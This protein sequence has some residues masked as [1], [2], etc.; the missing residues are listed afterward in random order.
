MQAHLTDTL[1]PHTPRQRISW[2]AKWIVVIACVIWFTRFAYLRI[3]LRPT[4][5]PEYWEGQIAALDPPGPNA[6][7][8][9][10][11]RRVFSNSGWQPISM[12]HQAWEPSDLLRGKWDSARPDVQLFEAAFRSAA[13]EAARAEVLR[14]VRVGWPLDFMPVPNAIHVT[15]FGAANWGRTLVAH[16]R[17]LRETSG[18]TETAFED[19]RTALQLGR[20]LCRA[21]LVEVLYG[22]SMEALVAREMMIAAREPHAQIEVR[23]LADFAA[24]LQ[25]LPFNPAD[26][27]ESERLTE[28][29]LLEHCFVRHGGD[30]L[31]ISE[32]VFNWPQPYGG[33]HPAPT[34][35]WNLASPVF[36][37]LATARRRVD[38]QYA[39]LHSLPNLQ[40]CERLRVA[41]DS[42]TND[43]MIG[44]LDGVHVLR[45][46]ELVHCV[47]LC[48][49]NKTAL[50]A[51]IASLALAEFHR[52]HGHYPEKLEELVPKFLHHVPIDYGDRKAL[53]YR[54]LDHD[55]Y[56]L[57]SI[58]VDGKDDGGRIDGS[59]ARL[60]FA[61]YPEEPD[62]VFSSVRRP[63]GYK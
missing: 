54:R 57:Y 42:I 9:T 13:F 38:A 24:Q 55:E 36:H 7:S 53:R 33:T 34:R 1:K 19:W 10:E 29:S 25:P 43:S 23:A 22:G 63:E 28:H 4:P 51:G 46:R 37:D 16:S 50:E 35:I 49:V 47:R 31:D 26:L 45:W 52:S 32:C 30:W 27:F 3:T 11:A 5:R 40:V 61:F 60:R 14:A 18:P 21:D 58:G 17:W 44:I 6:L 12:A 39:Y 48:Y 41:D 62:V 15:M 59:F 20:Q 8:V 2:Y 56:L